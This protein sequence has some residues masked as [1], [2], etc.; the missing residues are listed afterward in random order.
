MSLQNRTDDELGFNQQ[1]VVPPQ[2]TTTPVEKVD[3]QPQQTLSKKDLINDDE[4]FND[5]LQYR[6]DRFGTKKD[7]GTNV[8][9][10]PFL[11]G[12]LNKENLVDD[13][14]DN[15]RFIT[16]NEMNAV[17]ELDWLKDTTRKEQEAIEKANN[18]TNDVQ[19]IRFQNEAKKFGEIK[20]RA[21]RVYRKTN[22]LATIFDTKRFEGMTVG[23]ELFDI[24]DTVGGHIAANISA[25]LSVISL[26]AGKEILKYGGKKLAGKTVTQILLSAAT[27]GAIDATQAGVVD[28]V[29]QGAEKEMGIRENYDP[30]RTATVM[31]T[32]AL[33]SGTLSGFA[34]RNA[35][36]SD[37]GTLKERIDGAVKKVRETQTKKAQKTIEQKKQISAGIED[38]FVKDIEDTFGT[39]A[40]I[41]N[42][43]GKVTGVDK[44]IIKNA[45]RLEIRRVGAENEITEPAL[46]FDVFSRVVG[47]I[48]DIFDVANKNIESLVAEGG[49]INVVKDL[50]KPLRKE[51]M[52]SDRIFKIL[53]SDHIN[54]DIPFQILGQYGVSSKDFAAMV[55]SHTSRAGGTLSLISK[56]PQK[57][58]RANRKVT[59]E[60]LAEEK[61][62]VAVQSRFGEVFVRLE[63]ARRAALVSGVATAMRNGYAQ[64]P[65]LAIDSIIAGFEDILDPTKKFTF[66]GTFAQMK[67]TMR[68]N[69]EAA[70]ISDFLLDNFAEAKR[71]M[72]NQFS[73][74]KS[75]MEK[76]KPNQEA[77]SNTRT[78]NIGKPGF[79]YK[80]VDSVLE[81]YEGAIHHFNVFNRF[82]ESMFR[83]GALMGSL[84]RQLAVK[85]KTIDEVLESGTFL[86]DITDDMMAKAVDDALEFTFAAQ[87]KFLPFKILNN[88]IV[89]SGLTLGIPF[90]RFMFKAM[91]MAYNYNAFG[92]ATGAFRI[93]TR[94]ADISGG[95]SFK[96]RMKALS[97]EGD[98]LG[99]GAYRQT[100]EGI[101]GSAFLVPL[102]YMLR[103]PENDVAGSE[104]YKLKD[105]LVGEFDA[106]VY[107]PILVPYLL[108]GEMMHRAE[109]GVDL[110]K[111]GEVI[112]GI[113]G[114]NFRSFYS[115]EKTISEFYDYMSKGEYQ[116]FEKGLG[117]IARVLG[118]ASSG[119]LQPIYQFADVRFDSQR[120]RDYKKDP[121]YENTTINFL[122]R[123]INLGTGFNAFF[124]EFS[125][126]F[127]RRMDAFINDPNVP[128]QRSPQD[129]NIPERVL[130][131]MKILMGATLNRTPPDYIIELGRLGFSY[132]DF[133]AKSAFPE[134]NR[135]AN[136]LTAETMQVEFPTFLRDLRVNHGM[137]D[138]EIIG[139]LD[140][141]VKSIKS[142][143]MAFAKAERTNNE[144]LLDGLLKYQRLSPRARITAK[145]YFKNQFN[146]E[147]NLDKANDLR[148]LFELGRNVMTDIRGNV[149]QPFRTPK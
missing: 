113:T 21:A 46:D 53:L 127:K 51:E 14:I 65:R 88:F 114:T 135:K 112:E 17:A 27:T 13:M 76:A 109:R 100:A 9:V 146:R 16:S 92:A 141:Y 90:P 87:P 119:Y 54:K 29:V 147:P 105:N 130:P 125:Q 78:D 11:K 110:I 81:K 18:A 3:Q 99:K 98:F 111:G 97:T 129:P 5:V 19:R 80:R 43:S 75:R 63:N 132:K 122:G 41:R 23:E 94:M 49:D 71:R 138:Q 12:D 85:N 24:V 7:V 131:F 124:Q 108:I 86:D 1:P 52:I 55:L 120:R 83:R 30:L 117:A 102:G 93:M 101:A 38:S 57:I 4:Y 148:A 34:T 60:E 136:K 73:E 59:P 20:A 64:F 91:E 118:E 144:E 2:I 32:S 39:G 134:T 8:F 68:D 31:G 40:I 123:E 84:E 126:P 142:E 28:V 133:M 15:Y 139:Y 35:L 58:S 128:F 95:R 69:S 56:L 115:V 22:S 45:G 137:K 79:L 145:Y 104:W 62:A 66:R 89:K 10:L 77:L 26:G 96:D 36:K 82:Q 50:L 6:E 37:V 70:I 107:G 61:A 103:D 67:Y 149:K 25:P 140:T 47:G 72:W 116:D 106:R 42:K 48:T 74:V 143:S 44:E 33:V 121:I